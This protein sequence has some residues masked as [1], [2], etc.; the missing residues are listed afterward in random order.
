MV[1]LDYDVTRR[2]GVTFVTALVRNT[3]TTP[4]TV[5]L[6]SRLE[7]PVWP[8][9]RDGVTAPEWDGKTWNGTIKPG[10]TRGIGFASPAQ[11]T[12][13]PLELSDQN[14]SSDDERE[15]PTETLAE[16]EGWAPPADVLPPAP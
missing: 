16:L 15:T 8:P 2:D 3:Q 5:R 13:P 12:E 14:R 1:T 4:Q 11:P 9:R 7:G 6:E 10:R